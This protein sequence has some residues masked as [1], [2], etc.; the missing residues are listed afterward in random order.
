MAALSPVPRLLLAPP[1]LSTGWICT[2]TAALVAPW[3]TLLLQGC[4]ERPAARYVRVC[5]RDA[6]TGNVSKLRV[7]FQPGGN[8]GGILKLTVFEAE[9]PGQ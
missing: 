7:G 3:G 9:V 6:E 8:L 4:C 2:Q 5:A 1:P